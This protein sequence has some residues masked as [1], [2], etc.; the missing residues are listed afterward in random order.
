MSSKNTKEEQTQDIKIIPCI[1][2]TKDFIKRD[3]LIAFQK[4]LKK[5]NP[6]EIK[7]FVAR[8]KEKPFSAP[9]L[10]WQW[11]DK[12]LDGHQ[13]IKALNLL[14][15][16]WFT[17][18][19]DLIPVVL[20]SAETEDEAIEHVLEYNS[21]YSEISIPWLE[22]I[23]SNFDIDTNNL[24]ISE[25]DN[26]N[27]ADIELDEW[28]EDEVPE[29]NDTDEIYV[30]K[31]DIFQLW[32]HRLLCGDSTSPEDAKTLMDDNK[33]DFVFTDPPYNIWYDFNNNWM[34]Q[35][36]QRTARFWEIKNDKMS[37]EQ[38]FE[39][40]QKAFSIVNE[41]L[42]P[43]WA[44]YISSLRDC[45][46]VFNQVLETF[47]DMHIQSWLIWVKENFNISRLDYH[48]KHEIIT[49]WWKKGKA[50]NWHSDRSQVDVLNFSREI[51]SSVHPTQKPICL[52][53]YMMSNS[54]KKW[55]NILDL[56]WW[57]WATLIT[58]EKIWRKCFIIELDEKY[59][60][61]I[62]KRYLEYSKGQRAV[63]CLNRDFD[64]KKI[65]NSNNAETKTVNKKKND[66]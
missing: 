32:E 55:D 59:V 25:L 10:V 18:K 54:S 36:G 43:W 27:I 51:W 12:I 47:E 19:D 57:S 44:Y 52:I 28:S 20:I 29:L 33:I 37:D 3:K 64:F 48:P 60:Q 23:L 26:I 30:K 58:A 65:I 17:L 45:T 22:D 49:Y 40:I 46:I 35:T 4:D 7:Q 8:L 24:A 61:I 5:D 66:A 21:K 63:K 15:E 62:I 39:F 42:N 38:F 14:H 6:D 31:W 56:F 11:H 13:R 50:H 2:D 41:Y 34:V 1:V 9:L 53:E 16:E